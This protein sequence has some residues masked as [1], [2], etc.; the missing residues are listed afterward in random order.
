[1]LDWN[2]LRYFLA[3]AE[4]GTTLAAGR[5]LGV[6]QSTAARRVAALETALG[7]ELFEKSPAG[8]L[9]TEAAGELIEAA[10]AAEAAVHLLESKAAARKRGLSGVVRLTTTE[11]FATS[12]LLHAMRD[13]HAAYPGIR[14]DVI[15]SDRR[16]DLGAGE[17][18]IALR[19]GPRPD[20]PD[21]AGRRI[22]TERWAVYCSRAYA[23]TRGFPQ[24][25]DEIAGHVFIGTD[26]TQHPGPVANWA[27]ANVPAAAIGL[28]PSSVSAMFAAIRAG[29]GVGLMSD[30]VAAGD[31]AL[32]RCFDIGIEPPYEIWLLAHERR[33][34]AAQVRAVLD[35]LSGYF[36]SGLHHRRT[37]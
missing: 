9:P 36:A 3:V 28:R 35:Y 29:L 19:A 2:D 21:L 6:S 34:N 20:Q 16:L 27:A 10:R 23:D 37:G 14:L 32:L 1:M 8:Y 26:V 7:L 18:D 4:K 12:F 25:V 13:F 11:A 24:G 5:A 31:P 30:F 22:A 17:A 15:T 33:R